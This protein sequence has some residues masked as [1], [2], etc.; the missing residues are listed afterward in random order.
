LTT[1]ARQERIAN[2]DKL[3]KEIVFELDWRETYSY[4]REEALVAKASQYISEILAEEREIA[5]KP[6]GEEAL[7]AFAPARWSYTVL[8]PG[9]LE[10]DEVLEAC[11][12]EALEEEMGPNMYL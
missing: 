5:S 7:R 11:I 6:F 8:Q 9:Y 1:Q 4:E 12:D 10:Q 2:R 3:Q